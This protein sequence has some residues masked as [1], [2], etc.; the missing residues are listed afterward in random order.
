MVLLHSNGMQWLGIQSFNQLV[1]RGEFTTSL[2]FKLCSLSSCCLLNHKPMGLIWSLR[3]ES[4]VTV[5]N[6]TNLKM[7]REL[8]RLIYQL[9]ILFKRSHTFTYNFVCCLLKHQNV[10]VL[11]FPSMPYIWVLHHIVLMIIVF[12]GQFTVYWD[13]IL[14]Q[15]NSFSFL[16]NYNKTALDWTK[17]DQIRWVE[18]AVLQQT[19][20]KTAVYNSV[21]RAILNKTANVYTVLCKRNKQQL[22]WAL[23]IR[24]IDSESRWTSESII[25]AQQIWY[26]VIFS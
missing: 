26:A 21:F 18:L 5:K 15:L 3:Y 7:F 10:S 11:W 19:R 20:I 16:I 25:E 12:T 14:F 6:V 17:L 22:V 13:F 23:V 24:E 9:L 8:I 2:G 1:R 4:A